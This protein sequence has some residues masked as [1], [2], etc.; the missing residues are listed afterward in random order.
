MRKLAKL[1]GIFLALGIIFSANLI[2][3]FANNDPRNLLAKME[4]TMQEGARSPLQGA[5]LGQKGFEAVVLLFTQNFCALGV[6]NQEYYGIFATRGNRLYLNLQDGRK[7][8]FYYVLQGQTLVL[9]N[10]VRLTYYPLNNPGNF[11][12]DGSSPRNNQFGSGFG[13]A[14]APNAIPGFGASNPLEGTWISHAANGTFSMI[15]S[16]NTYSFRLNNQ[17]AERGTFTY[18]NGFMD[19]RI[20]QGRGAGTTGRYR[21]DF[22]G[23]SMTL[24]PPNGSSKTFIRR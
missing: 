19:Y 8:E 17:E 2:W 3:A 7:L 21:V 4:R 18:A 1:T 6:G 20:L 14:P 9:D 24:T 12:F 23:N 16:G 22:N 11:G 5:W 15:F 10:D 13:P